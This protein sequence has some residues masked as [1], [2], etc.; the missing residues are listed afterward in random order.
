ML[1]KA[2]STATIFSKLLFQTI[3]LQNKNKRQMLCKA[4]TI[5]QCRILKGWHQSRK[6]PVVARIIGKRVCLHRLISAEAV[7][8]SSETVTGF[9][10]KKLC[11]ETTFL[12][13]LSEPRAFRSGWK[14]HSDGS[15]REESARS[16]ISMGHRRRFGASVFSIA[17]FNIACTCSVLLRFTT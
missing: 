7:V 11:V 6:L 17:R 2:D 4:L 3:V 9:V 14:Q 15:R 16:A 1:L 5:K 10:A 13:V 12:Y 8:T